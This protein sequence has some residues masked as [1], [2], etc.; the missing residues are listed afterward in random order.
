MDRAFGQ[1]AEQVEAL[2]SSL[3]EKVDMN[4]IAIPIKTS[5]FRR[6]NF[7]HAIWPQIRKW[8]FG[9]ETPIYR[10]KDIR[11]TK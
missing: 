4:L 11:T 1:L 2:E 9:S 3:E 8:N 6:S 10:I 5:K 7:R